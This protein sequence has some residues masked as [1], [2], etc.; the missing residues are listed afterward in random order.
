[1]SVFFMRWNVVIGGQEIS[2]TLRGLLTY[3]MAIGGREGFL[4]AM[5]VLTAPLALLWA[6]T[7]VFPPWAPNREARVQEVP[8]ESSIR[9]AA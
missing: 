7:R 1:M 4:L 2:K 6:L 8:V 3:H 5:A 9:R